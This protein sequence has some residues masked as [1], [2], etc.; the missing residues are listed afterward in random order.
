MLSQIVWALQA[1]VGIFSFRV[2]I[3]RD[4]KSINVWKTQR[5]IVDQTDISQTMR[6]TT[7]N[8]ITVRFHE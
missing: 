3:V 1:L 5:L 8:A 6:Y 2:L 4:A 7:V